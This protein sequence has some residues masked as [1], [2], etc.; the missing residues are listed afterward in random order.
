MM[1][2]MVVVVIIIIMAI[3]QYVKRHDRLCSIHFTIC[4]EIGVN[5]D[6]ERWYEYTSKFV[7]TNEMNK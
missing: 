4:Q 2:M 7:E 6:K 1:M 3:E 5:L